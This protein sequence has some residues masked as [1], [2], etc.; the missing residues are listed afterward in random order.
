MHV[1]K[2]TVNPFYENT[3]L[4]HKEEVALLVDP[5][6]TSKTEQQTFTHYVQEHNLNLQAVVLTHAHVDHILGIDFIMDNYGADVYLSHKDLYLWENAAQQAAMF[7]I[8]LDQP[9]ITPFCLEAD[10]EVEIGDFKFK[11]LFT[12][13]H[14]PDHLSFYFHDQQKLIAGDTLFKQGIGRTDL[15]KGDFSLLEK[16][17]LE[18]I[19]TLPDNTEV[20]PGHGPATTIGF[21]KQHN[22]YVRGK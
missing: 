3:Y 5:G 13:G 10:K 15:Y 14:S 7:G 2:F 20:L 19:Y 21:E 11:T 6:F 12:P 18:K 4:I 1:I 9:K 22:S 17:I 8:S 16:S